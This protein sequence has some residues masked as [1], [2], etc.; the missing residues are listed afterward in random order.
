ME[1]SYPLTNLTTQQV[2]SRTLNELGNTTRNTEQQK[3]HLPQFLIVS[4][5]CQ[6]PPD[7]GGE[8]GSS[9]NGQFETQEGKQSASF[10]CSCFYLSPDSSIGDLVTHYYTLLKNTTLEHSERLVTLEPCY[11]S[12]KETWPGQQKDKYKYKD[13]DNTFKEQ[14]LRLLRHLTNKKTMT[15]TST[16]TNAFKDHLQMMITTMGVNNLQEQLARVRQEVPD[17]MPSLC[18]QFDRLWRHNHQYHQNHHYSYWDKERIMHL[19]RY[20]WQCS[21]IYTLSKTQSPWSVDPTIQI[22]YRN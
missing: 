12:D 11:Q 13:S 2:C 9:S 21:L 4:H 1:W 7:L 8:L 19:K 16:M 14:S 18:H 17:L 5:F 15:K 6:L 22:W 3:S 10:C 20:Y